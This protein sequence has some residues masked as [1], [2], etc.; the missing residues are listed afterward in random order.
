MERVTPMRTKKAKKAGKK[1]RV[2]W[3]AV[4]ADE[5]VS[6]GGEWEPRKKDVLCN[7]E[8]KAYFGGECCVRVVRAEIWE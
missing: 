2:V 3:L 5:G 4:N 6:Y 1:L 7:I 8:N